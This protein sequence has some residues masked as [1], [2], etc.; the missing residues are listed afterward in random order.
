MKNESITQDRVLEL[1]ATYGSEVGAWPVEEQDAARA[2]LT[3]TP[4]VFAAALSEAHTID[5]LLAS[6]NLPEPDP[7][8]AAAILA[9][10]PMPRS[11]RQ[12][13]ISAFTSLIFPQGV[14]WPAGAALAS[15][16]MGL[17]G[18]YA[19][20]STGAQHDQADTAYYL[21]FGFAGDQDWIET[22]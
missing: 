12:N 2:L 21:A 17:V 22:E 10:A 13:G 1:I 18:G 15:L 16:A 20:A 3:E 8:L 4:A 19:Y 5:A 7:G 14:R 9:S 6:E 11:V